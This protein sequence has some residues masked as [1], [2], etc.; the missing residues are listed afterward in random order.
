MEYGFGGLSV[1]LLIYRQI[2]NFRERLEQLFIRLTSPSTYSNF[3]KTAAKTWFTA[4]IYDL[5]R[6]RIT[7]KI[8]I[9]AEEWLSSEQIPLKIK[10][11]ILTNLK[12][13]IERGNQLI[14]LIQSRGLSLGWS[15]IFKAITNFFVKSPEPDYRDTVAYVQNLFSLDSN[16][17]FK[18]ISWDAKSMPLTIF[19]HSPVFKEPIL[20]FKW[21]TN[22]FTQRFTIQKLRDKTPKIGKY[23]LQIF[24][25][26]LALRCRRPLKLLRLSIGIIESNF[27]RLVKSLPT[28]K[29]MPLFKPPNFEFKLPNFKFNLLPTNTNQLVLKKPIEHIQKSSKESF[30]SVKAYHTHLINWFKNF[31]KSLKS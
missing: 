15:V 21:E 29:E 14:Y 2:S 19:E 24:T 17:R 16:K 26:G 5:N 10:N 30:Q 3:V 18:L 27:N 11:F 25:K 7:T 4:K 22:S 20:N 8:L 12:A 28:I 31:L 9:K 6:R 23:F 1:L 13:L